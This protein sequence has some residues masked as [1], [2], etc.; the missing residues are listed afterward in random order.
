M[1][2]TFSSV[3]PVDPLGRS[4]APDTAGAVLAVSATV[5]SRPRDVPFDAD[6]PGSQG[7]DE[8]CDD[9][10][11]QIEGLRV[12]LTEVRA[13]SHVLLDPGHV[14]VQAERRRDLLQR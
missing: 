13:R 6:P 1:T 14:D 2:A 12:D 4:L 9:H 8:V 10:L 11:V 5:L 7:V 3:M